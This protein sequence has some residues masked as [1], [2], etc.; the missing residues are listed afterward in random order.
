[1]T[2]PT[3][4]TLLLDDSEADAELIVEH[5]RGRGL[6]LA[7]RRVESAEA[8]DAALS[9]FDADVI[10][11]DH[12]LPGL[13]ALQALARA[14]EVAPTVP[15]ILVSGVVD[16]GRVVSCLRAGADAVVSKDELDH[17]LPAIERAREV[18]AGLRTLSSRQVEVLRLV[19]EGHTTAEAGER[20][21]ISVKTAQTHRTELMRRLDIHDVAGL[22]RYAV[23][24]RLV[25]PNGD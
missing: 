19:V 8:F 6:D 11:S 23:K 22:V 13:P 2:E 20:L 4:R 15:F 14:K 9:D 24:V 5:L 7:A 21:G 25:P 17:L 10:L 1:M 3:L 16:L 18:R 12:G